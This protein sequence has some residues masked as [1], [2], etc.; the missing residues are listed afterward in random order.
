MRWR[1]PDKPT[2]LDIAVPTMQAITH[3]RSLRAGYHPPTAPHAARRSL[4]VQ[5]WAEQPSSP[6]AHCQWGA[7]AGSRLPR[8]LLHYCSQAQ[9][10]QQQA[11]SN[12]CRTCGVDLSKAPGGCDGEGRIIGGLAAVPGFRWWPIKAYRPCP[13]LEE[14]GLEYVRCVTQHRP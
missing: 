7:P 5:V 1:N 13:G 14:A 11:S 6:H 8:C 2:L 4:A 12:V 9:Q 3:S 10:Q